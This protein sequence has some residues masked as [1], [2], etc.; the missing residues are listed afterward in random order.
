M[1]VNY[2]FEN[3]ELD[4]PTGVTIGAFDGVHR[5]HKALIRRMV[6]E[7]RRQAMMPV[8]LTFDPLPRQVADRGENGLLLTLEERLAHIKTLE[9]RGVVIQPFNAAL[10][11][12]T[13]ESFVRQMIN[14]LALAGLWIGP[15]FRFGR[16]REGDI[17][18][19]KEAGQRLGFEAHALR[20]TI[21]WKGKPVRSSRIRRALKEGNVEEAN[22]CLGYPYH[23]TGT[24]VHGDRRGREL[25]FPTANLQ[26]PSECLLPANGVYVCR[27]HLREG[28]YHAITNVGTRPTFNDSPPTVEAYLLDFSG[29]LYGSWM[30]VDFLTYL[31]PEER[32][33]SAD[34]LIEQ[35]NRDEVQARRWLERGTRSTL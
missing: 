9:V 8:V 16:D 32:F 13:A 34:E 23:L 1:W 7:A 14:H 26:I 24:V 30:R 33:A 12:T 20:E 5:G 31:R 15:D 2:G 22:G 10:M 35:M 29:D 11:R 28:I 4:Q 21:T 19:L 27:V 17:G 25:G 3:L 6:T 18:Y